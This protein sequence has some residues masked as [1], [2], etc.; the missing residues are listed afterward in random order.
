MPTWRHVTF[1][2]HDGTRLT[3]RIDISDIS[4]A[5]DACHRYRI[6]HGYDGYSLKIGV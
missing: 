2:R 1:Y 6:R 4:G 5:I 3:R